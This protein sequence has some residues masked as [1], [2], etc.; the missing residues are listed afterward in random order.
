[1]KG[2]NYYQNINISFSNK[3][4]IYLLLI[5]PFKMGDKPVLGITAF[6]CDQGCQFAILF[7]DKIFDILK[8]FDV[9][10]F[11]LLKMLIEKPVDAQK[12]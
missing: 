3:R 4:L 6:S 10:Y 1:M 11:H 5:F 12:I 8:K 7:I 2:I 9:Q